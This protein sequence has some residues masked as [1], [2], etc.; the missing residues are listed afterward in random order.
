[1]LTYKQFQDKYLGKRT[2]YDGSA[3]VQCVDLADAYLKECFGITNVWVI[4]ARDFYNNFAR[5]PQLVAKFKRIPNTRD[6]VVQQGDI[7]VWG[8]GKWGHVA[9]GT[10]AGNIDWFDSIEQNTLGRREGAQIVRHYFNRR[11]G[12][13]GC[14]PVLGVLRPI[15][16]DKTV[17]V[18]YTIKEKYKKQLD[19]YVKKLK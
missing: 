18:T 5:Y 19:E 2:D 3:G 14:H 4:G 11:W 7:V 13:D 9:I 16:Q 1:M 15:T 6:L 12:V 8:G 17:T 10:G